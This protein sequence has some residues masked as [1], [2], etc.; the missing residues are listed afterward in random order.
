VPTPTISATGA[1]ADL[2][3]AITKSGNVKS[4]HLAVVLSGSLP[5]SVLMSALGLP[6]P[7]ASSAPAKLDGSTVNADVDVTKGAL[8]LKASVVAGGLTKEIVAI[9]GYL[10]SRSSPGSI[11][12][13]KTALS[14]TA[15]PA[16]SA[17]PTITSVN[18]PDLLTGW[19]RIFDGYGATWS[20]IKGEK[21]EGADA[22]HF[23]LTLPVDKVGSALAGA[24]YRL[25]LSGL[26]VDL[27]MLA[28]DSR[29][30]KIAIKADA[31]P[32]GSFTATAIF[33]AYDS[34]VTI[35]VPPANE[36]TAAP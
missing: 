17:S 5:S 7:D 31:G 15:A 30:A 12:F 1:E 28:A 27:W 24:G 11:L 4:F 35:I 16:G 10:Y 20:E 36:T 2:L 32:D 25:S 18:L 19:I 14:G 13:S 6:T 8:H 26:S 29:P 33:S 22:V 3:A 34:P 9:G 23:S 21:V